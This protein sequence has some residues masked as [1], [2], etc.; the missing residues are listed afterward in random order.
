MK[1]LYAL[2]TIIGLLFFSTLQNLNAQEELDAKLT[3]VQVACSDI[4][5]N[6]SVYVANYFD[7]GNIDSCIIILDYWS[8]K[9][10]FTEPVSR[11]NLLLALALH[12]YSDEM[13]S[14][15]YID[16]MLIFM[17]RMELMKNRNQFSPDTRFSYD[18]Y[19]P[20]G[21]VFDEW[22]NRLA[23]SLI[24]EY[25]SGS[26]EY[27]LSL[28]YSGKCDSAFKLLKQEPYRA[29]AP[30]KLYDSLLQQTIELPIL[31][32]H[33]YSGV[34]IPTGDLKAMGVHPVLGFG[35]GMKSDKNSYDFMLELKFLNTPD[36]YMAKRKKISE[37]EPTRYFFGGYIGFEYSRDILQNSK[38]ELFY[39]IG[40][41]FDG[42]DMFEE[43]PENN[44]N[45]SSTGSY[46][47][48]MGGGYR[49]ALKSS[50]WLSIQGRYN[51]VD[52]T[53]GNIFD[54]K[55]HT[56]SLRLVYGYRYNQNR[57]QRLKNLK[58]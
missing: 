14:S 12:T 45:S 20:L 10:G 7:Q 51:V 6:S 34:W 40:A 8:K 37:S 13:I 25:E 43:D 36:F 44:I 23:G 29:T 24:N 30:G 54:L 2:L 58:Y 39:S 4:S 18:D 5:E 9:C 27:L 1:P 41:A 19:V 31:I 21:G 55:G 3:K 15:D 50:S 28:F 22:T 35:L 47:F 57:N 49:F 32:Y 33:L 56:V 46:N 16:R 17:N 52:Y 42:F 48:N 11:A 53:L 26:P 38:N